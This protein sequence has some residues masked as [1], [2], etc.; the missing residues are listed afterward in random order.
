MAAHTVS[1]TSHRAGPPRPLL[2]TRDEHLLDEVVRLSAEAG[3]LLEVAA[4]VPAALAGY[5]VAPLV[6]IGIDLAP[7]CLR[8]GLPHR[9]GVVVVGRYAGEGPPDWYV[10]DE[11]RAEHIA[12]LPTAGPWLTRRIRDAVTT[13]AAPPVTGEPEPA[14]QRARMVAVLGGRGGAG[15]TV[16]AAG[17]AVTAARAGVD[18][19][20]VDA[21]PLGGGLD[22]VLGWEELDGLRW[23][24]LAGRTPTAGDLVDALPRQSCLAAL[25]FDRSSPPRVPV[26]AV[27]QTLAAGRRT[28]DLIVVDLPRRFDD[29]ALL[30]LADADSAYLVVPAELRACAAAARVVE[31]AQRHNDRLSLIVRGPAPGGLTAQE[32]ADAL[33]LPLVGYLRPEPGL[34]RDLEGGSAPARDGRGP[35]A[36]LCRRLLG[37]TGTR[38]AA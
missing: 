22:L 30:A 7:S 3:V 25:S 13:P 6:L 9:T 10:A 21:D 28:R 29:G 14:R 37:L 19:M 11:L 15:A 23:P 35:L 1:R 33:G 2:V 24:A 4:D 18:T 31:V 38:A 26:D 12:A 36:V 16:L 27:A 5:P 32:V 8:A 17:L 34:A 20:L